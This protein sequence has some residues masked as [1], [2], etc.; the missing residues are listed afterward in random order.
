MNIL[1]VL[2]FKTVF[3]G[4]VAA[5]CIAFYLPNLLHHRKQYKHEPF[6]QILSN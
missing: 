6:M 2:T 5:S 1:T 3:S 4:F